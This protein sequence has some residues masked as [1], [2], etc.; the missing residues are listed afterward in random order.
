MRIVTWILIA[1]VVFA[2]FLE[3]SGIELEAPGEQQVLEEETVIVETYNSEGDIVGT[4]IVEDD[5]DSLG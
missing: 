1:L 3:M 5:D 2:F 4:E